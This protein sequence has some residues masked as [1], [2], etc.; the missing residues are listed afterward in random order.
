MALQ[1]DPKC[2]PQRIH[3][4]AHGHTPGSNDQWIAVSCKGLKA[5]CL[6]LPCCLDQHQQPSALSPAHYFPRSPCFNPSRRGSKEVRRPGHQI[7]SRQKPYA[8]CTRS[9]K[10]CTAR[11]ALHVTMLPLP[12]KPTVQ[13][14]DSLPF[15]ATLPAALLAHTS[16]PLT[17]KLK[18]R[19][20]AQFSV[21]CTVCMCSAFQA[22]TQ[23]PT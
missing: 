17:T 14:T 2:R 19:N 20:P 4:P 9:K 8:C 12:E 15:A 5:G 22:S 21:L 16:E 6:V 13:P 23:L 3:I 7:N 11:E 10:H 18:V 1:M